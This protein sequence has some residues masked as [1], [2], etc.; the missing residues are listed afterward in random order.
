MNM[1]TKEAFINSFLEYENNSISKLYDQIILAKKING[2]I[3]SKVFTYPD[4]Y[5]KL[6]NMENNLQIKVYC[7][8]VFEEFDRA[9][10]AFG[11]Y[12]EPHYYPIDLLKICNKS[13]F[14]HLQHKDYLGAMMS[15]GIKRELLGDLI[16][17]EECCYVPVYNEITDFIILNL[18]NINTCPCEVIIVDEPLKNAPKIKFEERAIV[19][20]SLRLD[21]I[22]SSLCNVSRSKALELIEGNKV[23]L[24][25]IGILK[26]D[27]L[28]CSGD[29][30]TIRGYGKF[31]IC[32]FISK[33]Q[34]Q[35][36]RISIKKYN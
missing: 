21:N 29:I 4:I 18:T 33:T 5:K 26:K 19:V 8:G 10:L 1:I 3:Y 17:D 15:L 9:M 30:L 6:K 28:L 32:D 34:S 24:N 12:E 16:L 20:T 35:R 31:K 36:L 27:K 11:C 7:N 23:L 14:K 25:H 22:I 13:K 2:T